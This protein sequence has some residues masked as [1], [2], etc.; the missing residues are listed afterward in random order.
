MASATAAAVAALGS[1]MPVGTR[2]CN[3][4][5]AFPCRAHRTAAARFCS[6]VVGCGRRAAPGTGRSSAQ[7]PSWKSFRRLST[8]RRMAIPLWSPGPP[9]SDQTAAR[10]R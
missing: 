6:S 4:L 5:P 2:A 9:P 8:S 3:A 10:S 1:A 7:R